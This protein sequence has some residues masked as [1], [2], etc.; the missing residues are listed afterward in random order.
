MGKSLPSLLRRL[1]HY[2]LVLNEIGRSLTD[3]RNAKEMV[4]AVRDGI[5]GTYIGLLMELPLIRF[6]QRMGTL[7]TR[8]KFFTEI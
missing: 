2:R 3:F 8:L 6:Q 1:Q 7:M 5:I 4:A